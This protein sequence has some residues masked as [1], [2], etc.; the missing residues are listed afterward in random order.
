MKSSNH[1]PN[2]ASRLVVG[3]EG[4][5]PTPDER[6]WLAQWRPHGVILFARNVSGF[7]QLKSLCNE[8]QDLVPG[9]EIMADHEGGPVSQLAR[10]LGRPPS[11]WTLGS[12]DDP[13]LTLAVQTETAR[14]ACAAGV[15]RI[16]APVAD[17]MTEMRNPVIGVRAFGNDAT[18]VAGQ[19][20]ASVRGLAQGGVASCL[21]HWP[22]HGASQQ[23]SHWESAD[24]P[25]QRVAAPFEAGIRA[26]C[27]AVMV[28]HLM[29]PG[30]SRP[31][32]LDPEKLNRWRSELNSAAGRPVQLVADDIT[33][34]GLREAMAG[35]G[36]HL[37]DGLTRGMVN[38]GDLPVKWLQ[39][40]LSAGLDLLLIRGIPWKTLPLDREKQAAKSCNSSLAGPV[41]DEG[42]IPTSWSQAPYLEVQNRV[43]QKLGNSFADSSGGLGWLDLT[44]ADRW[45]VA[46]PEAVRQ[47]FWERLQ[48]VFGKVVVIAEDNF[49]ADPPLKKKLNRLLVTSH[50]PL[51]LDWD[52]PQVWSNIVTK[53]GHCRVWG[54]PSL[55][56]E[57]AQI[58]GAG[59]RVTACH[60]LDWE[61]GWL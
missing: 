23:D 55:E 10:A 30:S 60:E 19:V 61:S 16:L 13:E 28:G 53:R 15:T 57:M 6:A 37:D 29:E 50:R 36:V 38:P 27:D 20:E 59:W 5:W 18:K 26:G 32:T 3:L 8:I 46:N 44:P 42:L 58:L 54:H 22:G 17:V 24:G 43:R 9:C 40:L 34:G 11:A 31:G 56:G 49:Q 41:F 21:K 45:E 33:M 35:L 4:F 2:V 7:S 39:Q 12:L 48:K 52:R 1:L 14:R 51:S 25:A 47:E